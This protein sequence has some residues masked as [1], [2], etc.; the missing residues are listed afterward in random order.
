MTPKPAIKRA[1]LATIA[2]SSLT[3]A[4]GY[5]SV[6]L[7]GGTPAWAPWTFVLGIACL[8]LGVM[9]LG[10]ARTGRGIG[11]LVL[12][13]AFIWLVLVGGFG[14]VLLLPPA[15]SANPVLWVGLPAGA[16]VV[17]YGIGLFPVLI[18]PL[19][20]ALTF[21]AITL[22]ETDLER[23]RAAGRAF[24]TPA[25]NDIDVSEADPAVGAAR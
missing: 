7:P 18:L 11:R 16:A 15:D 23:V 8:L 21:D 25:A 5:A 17:L 22:N 19:G 13:F 20:Y 6:F 3:I 9:T 2:L 14:L 12:P 1:A 24:R 4:A 10:A